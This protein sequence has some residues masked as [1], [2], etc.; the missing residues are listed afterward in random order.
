MSSLPVDPARVAEAAALDAATAAG[1]HAELAEAIDR[2]NRLYY[3]EDAP[4]LSDAELKVTFETSSM[5]R[6][7][8][9]PPGKLFGASLRKSAT[10]GPGHTLPTGGAGGGA[11]ATQSLTSVRPVLAEMPAHWRV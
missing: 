10:C 7:W 11:G 2:A 6:F 5:S 1:R 9:L 4:E 8:P 3:Q